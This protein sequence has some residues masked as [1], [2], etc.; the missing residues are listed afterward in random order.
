MTQRSKCKCGES[1]ANSLYSWN[2]SFFSA[3]QLSFAFPHWQKNSNFMIII[4]NIN[5][6]LEPHIYQINNVNVNAHH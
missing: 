2:K 4:R 3:L 5:L 6:H 1:T